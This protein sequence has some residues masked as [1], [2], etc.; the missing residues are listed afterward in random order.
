MDQKKVEGSI[1]E[2]VL[3]AL[4]IGVRGGVAVRLLSAGVVLAQNLG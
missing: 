4:I 3:V 1:L 2:M